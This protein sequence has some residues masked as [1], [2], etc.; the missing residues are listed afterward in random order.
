M[1]SYRAVGGAQGIG[2]SSYL[3]TFDDVV[4][5]VDAGAKPL[6][7]DL[8][9]KKY[10]QA[11]P[12]FETV[13]H[14][15]YIFITHGHFDHCG[16]LMEAHRRWPH[17]KI[18]MN[19]PTREFSK[20][21]LL[22]LARKMSHAFSWKGVK[23]VFTE[24]DVVR[25][26]SK[27]TLIR[28]E[29][30]I[31]LKKN[32]SVIPT[33]AGHILG[34]LSFI[35]VFG[36]KTVYHTGDISW[37]DQHFTP[38]ATK[39]LYKQGFSLLNL[40]S[41]YA[42]TVFHHCPKHDTK[43]DLV[44]AAAEVLGSGG[45]VL[46]PT[47]GNNRAQEIWMEFFLHQG[48]VPIGCV[49][50]DGSAQRYFKIFKEHAR[51]PLTDGL[52]F[53]QFIPQGWNRCRWERSFHR[54]A[55]LKE[56]KERPFVVIASGAMLQEGSAAHS[57]ADLLIDGKENA[58]FFTSFIDPCSAA[59]ELIE[60]LKD[61]EKALRYFKNGGARCS[62]KRFHLSGHQ[63]QKDITRLVRRLKPRLTIFTH[64]EPNQVVPFLDQ[65]KDKSFLYPKE[66]E[67]VRI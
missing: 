41:T 18:Y 52:R 46:I 63:D 21:H 10:K 27:I 29:E 24:D 49:F 39:F 7:E 62:I 12:D 61:D 42:N 6:Q 1:L 31:N 38:G 37:E 32:L 8:T 66:G 56:G 35:F 19:A 34:A 65:A 67:E 36:E 40:D 14:V 57:W 11:F 48:I 9:P 26:M 2:N 47:L 4:V 64:G 43:E 50:V 25:L 54:K 30:R 5:L 3:Y 13:S 53:A 33:G 55:L 16:G 51:T 60:D 22:D 23:P 15:D 28:G 44:K 17:A 59:F 45:N 20:I 58:I